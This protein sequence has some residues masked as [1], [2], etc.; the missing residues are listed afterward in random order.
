[1]AVLCI[2]M[3]A[4]DRLELRRTLHG[5][6]FRLGADE[7]FGNIGPYRA[8]IRPILS[9]YEPSYQVFRKS[10]RAKVWGD[11]SS[12]VG[13][14]GAVVFIISAADRSDH[15]PGSRWNF[16]SQEKMT[17]MIV[18]GSLVFLGIGIGIPCLALS[19]SYLR[20]SVQIY[21]SQ[22]D[23]PPPVGDDKKPDIRL[24]ITPHG[25]GMVMSW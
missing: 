8:Y 1:M 2:Q 12:L 5:R 18:G 11:L 14:G 4:Q 16:P 19:G 3:K 23:G 22:F 24:G 15:Q 21:N 13:V 6:E 20:E 25:V 17:G 7:E 9:S 10:H